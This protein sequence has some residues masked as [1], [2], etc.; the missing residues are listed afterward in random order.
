MKTLITLASA[1]TAALSIGSW[2]CAKSPPNH[3]TSPTEFDESRVNTAITDDDS[4]IEFY[5]TR[6]V[7]R[8]GQMF[9]EEGSWSKT[10]DMIAFYYS[11]PGTFTGM[12]FYNVDGQTILDSLTSALRDMALQDYPFEPAKKW[13]GNNDCWTLHIKLLSGVE[14]CVARANE[15]PRDTLDTALSTLV[16][17]LIDRQ[18]EI[19]ETDSIESDYSYY[20]YKPDGSLSQRI[21]YMSDGTVLGGYNP[22]DPLSSY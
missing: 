17:R 22:D 3:V 7:T 21:D 19:N 4:V 14:L 11:R 1:A 9:F 6:R 13:E 2:S 5:Y 15:T 10:D 16:N 18:L 8:E 12:K 20:Q